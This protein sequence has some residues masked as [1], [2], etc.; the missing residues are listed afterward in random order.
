MIVPVASAP[1]AH[2]TINANSLSARSSSCSAVVI[3]RAPVAH[4]GWPRAIAPP[5]TLTFSRS[6]SKT[7]AQDSTTEVKASLTSTRS[8]SFSVMPA[9]R[10]TVRVAP[11][12][13][14][15]W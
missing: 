13:P 8:M 7:C 12:G 9:L 14:Y 15:R 10:S 5:L 11:I 4:T 2:I 3:S 6:W 1:S